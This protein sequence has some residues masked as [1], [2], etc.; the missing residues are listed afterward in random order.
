[1]SI[2]I[3][4]DDENGVT[5]KARVYSHA[6]FRNLPGCVILIHLIKM[7]ARVSLSLVF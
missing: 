6:L 5:G 4:S 7:Y 1:M 2:V 3:F